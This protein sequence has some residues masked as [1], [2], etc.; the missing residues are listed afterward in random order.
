MSR[1]GGGEELSWIGTEGKRG[2]R[3]VLWGASAQV[4]DRYVADAEAAG[5]SRSASAALSGAASKAAMAAR[6]SLGVL[7][8]R[9]PL[10]PR[11]FQA[12]DRKMGA[13]LAEFPC[14]SRPS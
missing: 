8:Q 1:A 3:G 2:G 12:T 14:Y 10:P 13:Y 5:D 4:G 7:V 11:R 9:A 6:W